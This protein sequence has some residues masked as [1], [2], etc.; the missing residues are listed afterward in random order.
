MRTLCRSTPARAD[1]AGQRYRGREI[2]REKERRG[3]ERE[4]EREREIRV[5]CKDQEEP[6]QNQPDQREC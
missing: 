4:R 1:Q 2:V 3:R 5:S 6:K